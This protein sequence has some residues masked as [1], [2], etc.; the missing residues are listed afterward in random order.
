[1][2]TVLILG[3]TS[4]I[5]QHVARGFAREGSRIFLV[6]RNQQNLCIIAD[7]LLVRGAEKVGRY[8]VDLI[9]STQ[10]VLV[11]DKAIQFLG[12]IDSVLI[13]Y[14]TLGDQDSCQTDLDKMLLELGTNFISVVALLTHIA[15]YFE[16]R[17]TGQIAVISSVAGE[18]GRL[19]NYIYGAAKGGLSIFL[20]GMRNRLYKSGINVLTINPGFVDTPMTHA[21]NK[22]ILWAK[23]D[24]VGRDIYRAMQRRKDIIYVPWFWRWV[25]LIIK[26]IPEKIF[27]RMNL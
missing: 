2:S 14:G 5:A 17:G 21:F 7:D 20:Q 15:N 24:K 13:A 6:A 25:M 4:T 11:L 26:L 18:R 23:P 3:A 19:S 22:G 27:K 8:V 1:M 12:E 10:H 9:E 16:K